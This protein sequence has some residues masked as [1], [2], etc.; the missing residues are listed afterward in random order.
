MQILIHSLIQLRGI[1]VF[2]I[3][4][5]VSLFTIKRQSH[6][7][8]NSFNLRFVANPCWLY[9]RLVIPPVQRLVVGTKDKDSKYTGLITN[10]NDIES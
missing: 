7:L 2:K 9:S 4:S 6:Y 10:Y 5:S 8:A 1:F 3:L